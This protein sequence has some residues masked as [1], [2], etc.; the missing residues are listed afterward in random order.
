MHPSLLV[1]HFL[2]ERGQSEDTSLPVLLRIDGRLTARLSAAAG[3]SLAMEAAVDCSLPAHHPALQPALLRWNRTEMVGAG[4]LATDGEGDTLFYRIVL[5]AHRL[6][7]DEFKRTLHQFVRR[8]AALDLAFSENPLE[9][10]E[11]FT[12]AGDESGGAVS[13][14]SLFT[15]PGMIGV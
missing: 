14:L 11:H 12:F 10:A 5:P 7:M 3:D 2:Q 8:M 6:E 13:S 9:A 4:C 1:H 15:P